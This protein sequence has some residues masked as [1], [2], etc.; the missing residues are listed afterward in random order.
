MKEILHIFKKDIRRHWPEILASLAFL[1]L[2]LNVTLQNPGRTSMLVNGFS[3]FWFSAESIPPLMVVFWIFLAVRVVQG[4]PLVGDRQWWIT[5]PYEWWKLLA[6]KEVFQLV[7]IGLPLF[8]V[9]VYLLHHAGFP[10]FSNLV[11]V[12]YMQLSL[13]VV[14]FLPSVALAGLTRNLWQ[15]VLAAVVALVAF[16]SVVGSLLEKVPSYGMS[17]AV[18][19]LGAAYAVILLASVIGAVGWQFSRRKTWASRGLLLTGPVLC[20]LLAALTPYSRFVERKYPLVEQG[21]AFTSFIPAIPNPPAKKKKN[22]FYEPSSVYLRIPLLVS[23]IA[24]GHAVQIDGMRVT[25]E[26]AGSLRWDSSWMGQWTQLWTESQETDL[27]YQMKRTDFD[28]IKNQP[29]RLHLE[30][31]LSEYQETE[32][33]DLILRE[34]RFSDPQLG[35]CHLE[36]RNPSMITCLR[37]FQA[38]GLMA[39]FDPS[40][41]ACEAPEDDQY[42][43]DDRVSHTTFSPHYDENSSA[44][45]LNPVVDYSLGFG[46]RAWWFPTHEGTKR[47]VKSV[48]L[49]P[50]A[51]ITLGK[52]KELGHVRV[53]LDLDGVRLENLVNNPELEWNE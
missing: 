7:F 8:A 49:C 32:P 19:G 27:N 45:F 48:Y 11:R 33:R 14:I 39:S 9:Q 6:A 53:R 4:E 26:T 1:G 12:L 41:A 20:I 46:S 31:A 17:S 28:R 44:T 43:P 30:L 50:G 52:P 16:T 21:A 37:P 5:K 22:S 3:W 24:F 15:A 38:L 51:K 47:K 18:D 23:G 2:Y 36:E 13:A 42:V 35:I 25:V 10:V 34:G 29:A 40:K